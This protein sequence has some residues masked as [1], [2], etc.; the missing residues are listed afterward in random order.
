[1]YTSWRVT[2]KIEPTLREVILA[3]TLPSPWFLEE[4]GYPPQS[5]SHSHEKDLV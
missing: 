5:P 3:F 4:Q 1:M 2:S